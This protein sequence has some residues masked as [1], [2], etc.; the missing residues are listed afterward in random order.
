MPGSFSQAAFFY[1]NHIAALKV[2]DALEFGSPIRTITLDNYE[3]GPHID[4][5]IVESSSHTQYYQV[6]WSNDDNSPFTIYNLITPQLNESRALINDLVEGYRR[7]KN[8]ASFEIILF[9]T[10]QSSN[11]KRPSAGIDKGLSD[12][13]RDVHQQ[14][15]DNP[16][17]ELS[18]IPSHAKY[19]NVINKI[20]Q[21]TNLTDNEFSS[22]LRS[23]RFVLGQAGKEEQKKLID[24]RLDTLGIGRQSYEKLLVAAV[25]W[26]IAGDEI[27]ASD[28]VK[29]LG[30]ADRF[31]DRIAQDFPVEE[32]YF[33]DNPSLFARLESAITTLNGGFVL[34]E[35]PPGSGKSTYLTE[36]RKRYSAVRFAYYCFVPDEVALGNPR[37]EKETFLKSLCVGI[38]NSFPKIDFPEPYSDNYA[39]LLPMW[40]H[41]L[42]ELGDKIVFIIDGLDHVDK[43]KESLTA[44][45]THYLEGTLPPN[46][47]FLLSS[48]YRQA[49]ADGIQNQLLA[50]EH[51]V[52]TVD[53][54]S[55]GQTEEFLRKRGLSPT[56]KIVAL[57]RTKSEGLP[58]YLYYI[59]MLLLD[60]GDN[61]YL[62]E[63]RLNNLPE[64]KN[65]EIDTYHE[66]L[67][68]Q[69][70]QNA[71]AVGTLAL[72]AV[73]REFT[74]IATL[75]NL[76]SRIG[77]QSD[78]LSVD[79]ML[80]TYKHLFR[81]S[82]ARG[83]TILHNSFREF[84]LRKTEHLVTPIN[85][86]LVAYYKDN[87]DLDETYRNFYRH[88]FELR[89]YGEILSDC[90]EAW[91]LRS[92]HNFRP[93]EEIS[94]NLNLAWDAATRLLSLKEFIRVA[95]LEQRFGRVTA[96]FEYA[97]DYQPTRFL[98]DVNRPEEGLR[99]LWDGETLRCSASEFYA[100]VTGYHRKTGNLLPERITEIGF[101]QF[102]RNA[103][104]GEITARF[105]ALALYKA[106]Q[107]L[108][109]Q[110]EKYEWS[111]T[112]EHTHDVNVASQEENEI[113]NNSIKNHVADVLFQKGDLT[114]L[115]DISKAEALHPSVTNHAVLR[116]AEIFVDGK[117]TNEATKFLSLLDFHL[118]DRNQFNQI[119]IRLA[120]AQM[121]ETLALQIPNR[122]AP[123]DLFQGLIKESPDYTLK[124]DL[125]NLYDNLRVS[126]VLGH[127]K[128]NV[129]SL[130]ALSYNPP[131]RNFFLALTELA[132]LWRDWV[133][134]TICETEAS[135]TLKRI[136]GQLN[137]DYKERT[138]HFEGSDRY[139]TES[140]IRREVHKIY[141]HIFEFT[142]SK[143]SA[144]Y[145]SDIVR[146]WLD[147]DKG[148]AGY[149]NLHITIDFAKSLHRYQRE[150][151]RLEIVELLHWA[152]VQARADEETSEL[153]TN[154]IE[155]AEACGYC[156]L[157]SDVE[158]LWDELFIVACGVHGRKDYQF[159]Q[160]IDA[161]KNAHKEHPE[162]SLE[163]L[164]RLLNMAHQL[165]GAA[166]NRAVSRAIGG[167]I[168]FSCEL[169]PALAIALLEKEET[170]IYRDEVIGALADTLAFRAEINFEYVWAIVRTMDKWSNFRSYNDT[171][172]P[173][174][175][176]AFRFS[177]DGNN[178]RLAEEIYE[179]AHHQ[180]LVEKE[181]PGR[182]GQFAEIALE[183]G[184]RFSTVQTDAS[185]YAPNWQAE[186]EQTARQNQIRVPS[187][188][189]AKPTFEEL[190]DLS[191]SDFNQFELTLREYAFEHS[192]HLRR[193]EAKH[194]L[195]TLSET[196]SKLITLR[197]PEYINVQHRF[198]NAR[199]FVEFRRCILKAE[200]KTEFE[201]VDQV[202][203]A[204]NSLADHICRPTF[205]DDWQ[206]YVAK[207]FDKDQWVRKFASGMYHRTKSLETEIIGNNL[208]PLIEQ[209]SIP[210]LLHWE[211]FCRSTHNGFDL[212]RPL[213]A[214]AAR[215]KRI[216]RQHALELL[217]EAWTANRDFFYTYGSQATKSFL[218][219]LFELDPARA[220]QTILEGFSHQYKRYPRDI[221]YHLDQITAYAN[222]FEEAEAFEFIYSEYE[223]YNQLLVQGLTI[224]EVN[225]DWI[226]EFPLDSPFERSVVEYLVHMY[227]YP[228]VETRK[229]ALASLFN[230]IRT[231][232]DLLDVAL[233]SWQDITSNAK[234]HL[235]SLVYSLALVNH[236]DVMHH[237][238]SIFAALQSSHFNIRQLAKEILLFCVSQGARM[239]EAELQS[240]EMINVTPQLFVPS[241][242]YG[243]LKEGQRFIPSSYQTQLLRKLFN[244][245]RGD[246]LTEK[247]YTN[248]LNRGWTSRSGMD[249]EGTVRRAH[250]INTNF[251]NIEIDGPYF[252]S[253][254]E[255][256][257]ETFVKE[258]ESQ[259]YEDEDIELL[260]RD[261]RLYDP[262]DLVTEWQAPGPRD[263]WSDSDLTDDEFLQFSDIHRKF[264]ERF[265]SNNEF[266]SL[267]EDGHQRTEDNHSTN[268][269][270]YFTISAFLAKTSVLSDLND[271]VL[272][273]ATL[274]PYFISHNLF[275]HEIPEVFPPS[276]W[277]PI[278][279]IRPLLGISG[280]LFRGQNELSI[281]SL[282]P[283]IIDELS[284]TRERPYSLNFNRSD[285]LAIL[286]KNWQR[287]YDQDRRRRKPKA[288]GVGLAIKNEILKPYLD[289]LHYQLCFDVKVRRS[290]DRYI[291]ESQM[292]WTS[293]RR[294]LW[295]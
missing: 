284:L 51:R 109:S 189:P 180:L 271:F 216:N 237:K 283:D 34:L 76:L 193:S 86:A 9:S 221:V 226:E 90:N 276:Q 7:I 120:E 187:D 188:A 232:P 127:T 37:L 202:K 112:D 56:R 149:K 62:Q 205:G 179:Y 46:V 52:I 42:S 121:L 147:L 293:F 218:D 245:H 198:T 166:D 229:L 16:A 253:V 190:Q 111:S 118:I 261:F 77:V 104:V 251:D 98:L 19:I 88:L 207:H 211:R 69:I 28:V 58:I 78:T 158:R 279:E 184:A 119:V 167:L 60:V 44:P 231:K 68:A 246:N 6:K 138:A 123:P 61:E 25:E 122:F 181:M 87:P 273:D 234:E 113:T 13:L 131:E 222:S 84:I 192:T 102:D 288:A 290:V 81:V 22:F 267:Y 287:S 174:M 248:L 214:I 47:F 201:F 79:R 236:Y 36:F 66:T 24:V 33:V 262:S 134:R 1:Q 99:R 217:I 108:F 233:R 150:T 89:K 75:L 117:E 176:D 220:K 194:A 175:L 212:T 264:S 35:G 252:T 206:Q 159:S 95:F 294:V 260:K 93:F 11:Q 177:L 238:K 82:D 14:L 275:R 57:A 92:W 249:Q 223:R 280:N 152:E 291:P 265:S 3:K 30:L 21:A 143:L 137:L 155:C 270:T 162:R 200:G 110:I 74:D 17:L 70:S 255:V 140:F 195:S 240:V 38:R 141:G 135:E 204:F 107:P 73:R 247:V 29:R 268:R 105:K 243:V 55:E 83:Y 49:L 54:L 263:L 258:I 274:P 289:Q 259:N 178:L 106:W 250:N 128:P 239:D 41:R 164:I 145:F 136:L 65:N 153:V 12:F 161:L 230:L 183:K 215:I 213:L 126:F 209:A 40:L 286:W 151:A 32:Q 285:R 85:N 277:F 71:L 31:L 235:L 94:E 80:E 39:Q 186:Q 266:I 63:K 282:L 132:T 91:L 10:K 72:L 168:D 281:A 48:Q 96:S 20:Q 203:K 272:D 199:Y 257:N 18:D 169:S 8:H 144:P 170:S 142:S 133:R 4:D 295:V 5:I 129:Y 53:K 225:V 50:D 156:G 100:F 130:R 116:A 45:L 23:L 254:Q 292:N 228:P 210:T 224:K 208:I 278:Q 163:R 185:L 165:W 182:L 219:M 191:E 146:Y 139:F 103:S 172:Y 244:A 59:A 125:L 115:L 171:T 114:S 160:V 154:L 2:L 27:R 15:V 157:D 64:L 241:V 269:T 242:E 227:D 173:T 124:D 256:L 196:L 67:Y 197:A 26:S 43:K 97:E 148:S 101:R